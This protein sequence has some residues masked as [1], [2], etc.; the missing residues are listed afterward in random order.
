MKAHILINAIISDFESFF[1]DLKVEK[2]LFSSGLEHVSFKGSRNRCYIRFSKDFCNYEID[3]KDKAFFYLIV[4]SHELAHYLNKHH[5]I[6]TPEDYDNKLLESWADFYGGRI[7]LTIYSFGKNFL[8]RVESFISMES[9]MNDK[10]GCLVSGINEFYDF[11]KDDT[12]KR[13]FNPIERTYLIIGGFLSFWYRYHDYEFEGIYLIYFLK[14]IN[15]EIIESKFPVDVPTDE[16]FDK[17]YSFHAE[18]QYNQIRISAEPLDNY[19]KYLDTKYKSPSI[20]KKLY[21]SHLTD[22]IQSW[23]IKNGL[24]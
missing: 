8:S 22:K 3:S 24:S 14:K 16:Q 6:K 5:L 11:I 20:S 23:N 10:L 7:T 17:L 21:K 1:C 13:Y 9:S 15:R 18:V 2:E 19:K 12:S 4:I